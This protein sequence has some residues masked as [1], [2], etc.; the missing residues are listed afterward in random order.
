MRRQDLVM[1][2]CFGGARKKSSTVH[3]GGVRFEEL[4]FCGG[5][6]LASRCT[7]DFHNMG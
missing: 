2:C 7:G 3:S 6:F 4:P 5:P 1:S